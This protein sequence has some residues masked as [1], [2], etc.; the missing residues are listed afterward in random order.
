MKTE[1]Y[2]YFFI[3]EIKEKYLGNL[4]GFT[5]VFLQPVITLAI[6]WLVFEKIFGQRIPEAKEIGFIVYLAI[7]FWPW[8]AFSESLIRSITVISDKSDLIGKVNI[9]FKI[10][11]I[12]S[13]TATFALSI[14]G[15][16]IVIL[17]LVF[18]AKPFAHQNIWLLF[19]PVMQLYLLSLAIGLFLASIQI[20]IKDTF[21]FMTT[22]ITMWFFLTPILYSESILPEEYK[23]IIQLNPLYTPITFI[24]KALI[25]EEPLPWLNMGILTMVIIFLIYMAI[26]VFDKLSPYFE[27]YK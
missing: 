13:I 19:F 8:I 7:G 27:I 5:W 21:Q 24:H 2:K 4:T 20:F 10:P 25:T 1:L 26:K 6:Y 12:A 17:G 9:D 23:S 3:R 11:V 18:F 15:Y 22:I 14:L 16:I